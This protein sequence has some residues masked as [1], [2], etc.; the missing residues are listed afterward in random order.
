MD[1]K[2]HFDSGK[3]EKAGI[4]LNFFLTEEFER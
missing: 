2:P 1:F 4:R 3:K